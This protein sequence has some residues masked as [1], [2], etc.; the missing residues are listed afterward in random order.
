VGEN[1]QATSARPRRRRSDGEQTVRRLLDAAV[2]CI[3]EV[4]YY[5]ASSNVIARHAG[6]T[7]GAI[8][9]Q[10]GTREGLLLAI[11]EDRWAAL[12]QRLASAEIV[13]ETLEER[14]R[15]VVDVLASHYEQPD[16]LVQLLILLDLTRDP[17][18]SAE[19]REAVTAHAAAM[20]Q[21]WRPLFEAAIGEAAH[22]P[23]LVGYVFTTLRGYLTGNLFANTVATPRDDTVPRDL[24]VKGV[25]AA[26]RAE[27]AQ[28]GYVLH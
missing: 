21:V 22:D 17:S 6:V 24:L 7:W 5:R 14:L 12:N 27:A 23:D 3:R 26:L 11:L 18:T 19:A 1:A 13:G 9:H 8:Q 20:T 2:A 16:H 28:R 15:C 25:A 4:G 10:F